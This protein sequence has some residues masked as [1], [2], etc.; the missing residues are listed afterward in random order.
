MKNTSERYKVVYIAGPISGTTDY[1]ERFKRAEEQLRED[2]YIPVNPTIVSEPLVAA[3][4]EYE[5]FMR[6]THELLRVCGAILLLCDW[7]SSK[8]TLRELTYALDND[9]DIYCETSGHFYQTEMCPKCLLSFTS[10]NYGKKKAIH[11]H[12]CPS[13]GASLLP[14]GCEA[15]ET[16]LST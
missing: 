11:S 9:Y 12:Y 16:D 6:V 2:G 1:L 4:C 15:S 7:E 8:G 5:E 10:Y 14:E 13:C 3:G